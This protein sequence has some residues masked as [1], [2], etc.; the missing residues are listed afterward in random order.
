VVERALD[1]RGIAAERAA[2]DVAR[3]ATRVL[4][5]ANCCATAPPQD[6]PSTSTS[7]MCR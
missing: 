2:V 3:D 5:I 6:T 7:P 4:A 1:E